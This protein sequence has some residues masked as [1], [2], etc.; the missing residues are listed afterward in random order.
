MNVI[1][2]GKEVLLEV[3]HIA[4]LRENKNREMKKELVENM[5]SPIKKRMETRE[6][7]L[8]PYGMMI[9]MRPCFVWPNIII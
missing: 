8:L 9:I 2:R 3:F 7:F 6:L 4:E 1:N 5:N